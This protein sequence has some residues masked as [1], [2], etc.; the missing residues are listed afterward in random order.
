[1]QTICG[2]AELA[3]R[4]NSGQIL[5]TEIGTA[6]PCGQSRA[7]PSAAGGGRR[8][9]FGTIDE[10][11]VYRPVVQHTGAVRLF[12][13]LPPLKDGQPPLTVHMNSSL[14]ADIGPETA[15]V[16]IGLGLFNDGRNPSFSPAVNNLP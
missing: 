11:R 2:S 16:L 10:W 3:R 12:I 7:I 5:A 9:D 1:M 13:E 8:P 6:G 15:A 4:I 14:E